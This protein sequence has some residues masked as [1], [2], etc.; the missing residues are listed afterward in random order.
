MFLCYFY[1]QSLLAKTKSSKRAGIVSAK[2]R[3]GSI[4]KSKRAADISTSSR[5]KS[6]HIGPASSK[7]SKS[8]RRKSLAVK[9]RGGVSPT[10]SSKSSRLRRKQ[11]AAQQQQEKQR[12]KF[13]SDSV[14]SAKSLKKLEL[15]QHMSKKHYLPVFSSGE[16][17]LFIFNYFLFYY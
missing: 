2:R 11:L 14:R 12:K 15:S 5:R 13:A 10:K 1:F 9:K 16:Q 17:I 6:Y 8:P 3:A 7:S 4:S